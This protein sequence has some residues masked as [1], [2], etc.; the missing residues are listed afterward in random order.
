MINFIF[1]EVDKHIEDGTLISEY[2]MSALPSLCNHFVKLIAYL[3]V[4]NI[5][6]IILFR[7]H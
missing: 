3:V 4:F 5:L 7:S 6:L 1:S 2:N